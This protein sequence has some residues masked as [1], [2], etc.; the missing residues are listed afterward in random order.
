MQRQDAVAYGLVALGSVL[1]GIVL[2]W[3]IVALA[4][5]QLT[6]AGAVLG[7]LLAAVLGLPPVG[8]GVYIMSR[9][10]QEAAEEADLQG[11]RR[12]LEADRLFRAQQARE[13]TQL[14]RRLEQHQGQSASG[15]V[16]RLRNL[17]E[18]LE[19][20]A[21]D[22]SGWY[23]AVELAPADREALERYDEVLSAGARRMA[24]LVDRIEGDRTLL[25][26]L[27]QAVRA[28]EGDFSR[29][30]DL[31]RGRRAAGVAA[32]ELLKAGSAEVS[33]AVLAALKAG[34]AISRDGVD[35]LVEASVSYFE[36]GRTSLVHRL[37]TEAAEAWLYVAPGGLKLAWLQE[38][39]LGERPGQ[40]KL[41]HEGTTYVLEESSEAAASIQTRGGMGTKAVVTVWRY[42][43]DDGRLLRV[44]RWPEGDRAYSGR[45]IV[46]RE[47]E[48]WAAGPG[49]ADGAD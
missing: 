11:Q 45:W 9:G 41:E 46:A 47:L 40:D 20:P 24:E 32:T 16:G 42:R 28:W 5:G 48:V 13:L 22:R 8:V 17:V 31:L 7:L 18:D 37:T 49:K 12:T 3:L 19:S 23:E 43:G 1:G 21:Y 35:Y 14:A 26:Q 44:E 2:L 30:S 39:K 33:G 25:A 29:R 10:K 4:Q 36:A 15:L 38:A 34:D 6:A 27:E